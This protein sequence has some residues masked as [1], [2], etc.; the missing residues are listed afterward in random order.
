MDYQSPN[1]SQQTQIVLPQVG[2]Q[3]TVKNFMANV[4][5]FMFI[6]LG[7]SALVAYMFANNQ[8][9][10]VA[11]ASNKILFYAVMFAPLGFVL[12]MSF[13]YSRLSAPLM[14][15]L[16]LVY[17]AI[18]GITFGFILLVYSIGSVVACFLSASA[19]FGVMAF[20]GYTTKK[21][22]TSF[23][24]IMFMGLIGI[25]IASVI[26]IFLGSSTMDY[27][28]SFIGVMVFTGLT[29]Y[30]V[31]KLKRIG[32]GIEMEG[33]PAVEVRKRSIMGA[34]TLYL[35]FINLFLMLLRLFGGR[36]D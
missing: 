22:L 26:N 29:A 14:V 1:H 20:M 15:T 19:M 35:D 12:L 3:A 8:E 31:Q 5:T 10:I 28:I 7:I 27:I 16:F 23:G 24:R 18:N 4:F 30:D 13:G 21:D 11:L 33:T 6:A 34:L 9:W 32:E 17:A 2:E 36:R 25:I